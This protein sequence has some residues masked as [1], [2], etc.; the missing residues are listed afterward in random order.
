LANP[1]TSVE[2]PGALPQSGVAPGY[3]EYGLWSICI[4]VV[5]RVTGG[6][7]LERNKSHMSKLDNKNEFLAVQANPFASLAPW[8]DYF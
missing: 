8:R 3:D 5:A 2:I 7:K 4:A 6:S 1:L